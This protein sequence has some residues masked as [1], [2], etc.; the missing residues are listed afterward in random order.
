MGHQ[1]TKMLER[2]YVN[3]ATRRKEMHEAARSVRRKSR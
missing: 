3:L 1:S 2:Y